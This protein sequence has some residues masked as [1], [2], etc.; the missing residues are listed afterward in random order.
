VDENQ[1]DPQPEVGGTS[2]HGSDDHSR[3]ELEQ[4]LRNI[5]QHVNQVLNQLVQDEVLEL[6]NQ[7]KNQIVYMEVKLQYK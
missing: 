1:Q 2:E 4:N 3:G 6:E 7:F 5:F